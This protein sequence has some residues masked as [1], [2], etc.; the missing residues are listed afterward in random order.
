M[1]MRDLDLSIRVLNVSETVIFAPGT[2]AP[3][4]GL[5]RISKACALGAAA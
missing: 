2:V 1:A 5:E 3:G 4:A